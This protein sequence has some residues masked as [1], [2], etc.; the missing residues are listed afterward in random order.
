MS[1]R[2]TYIAMAGVVL[3]LMGLAALVYPV[4]LNELDPYGIKVDCGSGLISDLGQARNANSDELAS[5]CEG[6]LLARRAWSIPTLAAGLGLIAWFS[7][8]W[9][10]EEQHRQAEEPDH[11]VPHPEI[12][13]H[14]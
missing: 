11:Y 1:H 2:H 14:P 13:R 8:L 10:R 5:D 9:V 6:A 7:V 3:A 12:A 4:Y